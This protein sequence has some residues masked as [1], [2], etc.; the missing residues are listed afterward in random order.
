MKNC[1]CV[2]VFSTC[3]Q[4]IS[5]IIWVLVALVVVTIACILFKKLNVAKHVKG[6]TD[7]I[8]NATKQEPAAPKVE[9]AP[10]KKDTLKDL[11]NFNF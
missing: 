1:C 8:S 3:S 5:A 7:D 11:D 10:Q 9:Q 2:S 4:G 6:V